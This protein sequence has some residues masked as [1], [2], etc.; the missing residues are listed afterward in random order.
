MRFESIE[1]SVHPFSYRV[2]RSVYG[3]QP[4]EV[5][6]LD[7]L[8]AM[9]SRGRVLRVKPEEIAGL[10]MRVT[11]KVN[12]DLARK[13][14]KRGPTVGLQLAR[15]HKDWMCSHTATVV[16][17][18]GEA[19][20]AIREWYR[21]HDISEDDYS[22]ET[23]YKYWQRFVESNQLFFNKKPAKSGLKKDNTFAGFVD[24]SGELQKAWTDAEIEAA[25]QKAFELAS[26]CLVHTPVKLEH[27]IR[28]YIYGVRSAKSQVAIA[29]RLGLPNSTARLRAQSIRDWLSVD[30]TARAMFDQ[31]LATRPELRPI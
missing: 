28:A 20:A 4:I 18:S 5:D 30:A 1:I 11:L 10:K 8:F 19:L 22:T 24:V 29:R 23:A 9:L 3:Q 16:A 2:L 27:Q 17:H 21:R 31:I 26:A 25:T 15:F 6:R 12:A 13:I 7:L 14:K